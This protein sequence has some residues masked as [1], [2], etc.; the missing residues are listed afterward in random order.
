M[1]M[2][3]IL[4]KIQK[5]PHLSENDR[6]IAEY[7]IEHL[8][9]I[10]Q[11]SSREFAKRTY[12]S[13]T[14]IVRFVKKL[15]YQNYNDFK[16]HIISALKNIHLEDYTIVSNEDILLT[17]NKISQFEKDSIDYTKEKLSVTQF[18]EIIQLFTETKFI[19]IIANDAN[20]RIAQYASHLLMSVGK[21]VNIYHEVDMQVQLA[22]NVPSDH[23]VMIISKHSLNKRLLKLAGLLKKRHIMT[24]AFT[25]RED[26]ELAIQCPYQ[27]IAPFHES[28]ARMKDLDFFTS[29]KYLFDLIYAIL[30][31]KTYEK[32][33]KLAKLY[34][35]IFFEKL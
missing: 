2:L 29:S 12:T 31:S 8:E 3:E 18:Q 22:L 33:L 9:E 19:D 26:N 5:N 21:I 11:L 15:G 34:D 35:E 7:M 16:Y 23:I 10:P 20:A 13:A 6:M 14:S 25:T 24:I 4:E 27:L 28:D 32:S 30:L 17:I 1:I